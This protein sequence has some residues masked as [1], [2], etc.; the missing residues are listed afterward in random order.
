MGQPPANLKSAPAGD[1]K[2]VR[3]T[4]ILTKHSGHM[5]RVTEPGRV[6]DESAIKKYAQTARLRRHQQ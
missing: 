4:E 5:I 3:A 1:S 6:G 2:P